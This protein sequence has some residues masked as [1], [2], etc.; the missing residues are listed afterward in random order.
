MTKEERHNRKSGGSKKHHSQSFRKQLV[1][2]VL[3]EELTLREAEKR[4][5]ISNQTISRW[6]LRHYD[7]IEQ[8]NVIGSM[9]H[10]F[11][12]SPDFNEY[13]SKLRQAQLKI[14]ALET[15]IELAEQTY[16]IAIRKNSGTK[17]PK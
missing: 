4:F 2:T 5:G 3:Q 13:E 8:T 9:N 12:P 1:L 16:K 10:S 15:M 11:I 17:Q 7:E 6:V 14:T